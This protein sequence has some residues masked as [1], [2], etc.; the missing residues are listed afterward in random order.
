MTR[1]LGTFVFLTAAFVLLAAAQRQPSRSARHRASAIRSDQ[2]RRA[3]PD[4]TEIAAALQAHLPDPSSAV[5][6][7]E[8]APGP[9]PV[10]Q[11][12][13]RPT[14]LYG[15]TPTTAFLSG[16]TGEMGQ[17]HEFQ[18]LQSRDGGATWSRCPVELPWGSEIQYLRFP[19]TDV[20]WIVTVHTIE[21][22]GGPT[23]IW[24][25]TDGGRSWTP[26]S[27][28]SDGYRG[29]LTEPQVISFIDEYRG[30]IAVENC[31]KTTEDGRNTLQI[32]GT[33]DGGRSW[34]TLHDGAY[35]PEQ[36][37]L[38]V[39]RERDLSIASLTD[40]T[41]RLVRLEENVRWSV[42]RRRGASETWIA[43]HEFRRIE[44]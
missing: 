15:V 44:K 9:P 4:P 39:V 3:A 26:C 38:R 5:P 29:G 25:T 30:W 40:V 24:R 16:H 19:S 28:L 1:R 32:Y 13:F 2:T 10:Q 31:S 7:D 23:G 36:E 42:E 27:L 12:D 41:W 34:T 11:V 37:L 14:S 21:S 6:P 17:D 8:P 43:I 20:G 18:L 22:M 35:D 33:G